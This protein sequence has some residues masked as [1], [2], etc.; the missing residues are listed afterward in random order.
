MDLKI[1]NSLKEGALKFN[2][3]LSDEQLSQFY[4]YYEMLIKW[5][6]TIN[7]TA[8]TDFD[9]VLKK[10]FFRQHI[11]RTDFK[12]ERNSFFVRCR[13]RCRFSRNTN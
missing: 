12:T 13:N 2:I 1:M 10:T 3:D 6:E 11:Y 8:I 4:N 9:E 7:L 5:N